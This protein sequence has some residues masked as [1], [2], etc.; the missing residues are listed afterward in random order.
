MGPMKHFWRI[1]PGTALIVFAAAL[2]LVHAQEEK[3]AAAPEAEEVKPPADSRYKGMASCASCHRQQLSQQLDEEQTRE[4]CLLNETLVFRSDET[5]SRAH[6]RLNE[7]LG[8]R[9]A[10]K[11][12]YDVSSD[13]RC[14]SCHSGWV[15]HQQKPPS[16]Q[17]GVTCEICHGPSADWREPHYD[18]AWRKKLIDEK[19]KLGMIEVREPM[20][21]A[22]LCYSCHIGNSDEGKVVSHEMYAAGHPPLP[23][24]EIETFVAAMPAHSRKLEEKGDFEFRKEF[25]AAN[26]TGASA[27]T[28]DE[29][30]RTKGVLVGGL[31]ALRESLNLF[32]KQSGPNKGT[33]FALFDCQ[34]CHHELRVPAWR[35]TRL[36]QGKPG[37]PRLPEWPTVLAEIAVAQVEPDAK[38]LQVKL[39]ELADAMGEKPFGGSR[40]VQEILSGDGKSDAGLIGWLDMR[41]QALAGRPFSKGDAKRALNALYA[42]GSNE[43]HDFHSARQIAWAIRAIETEI[44]LTYPTF[45]QRVANLPLEKQRENEENSIKIWKAWLEKDRKAA[46]DHSEKILGELSK[47]LRLTLPAGQK[48]SVSASLGSFL[49]TS[50]GYDPEKFKKLLQDSARLSGHGAAK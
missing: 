45:P 8:Q 13:Q 29:L 39:K 27:Q 33:E 41:A 3:A 9:M 37:R 16:F 50:A 24:I 2:P 4:F 35:Q 19:K 40:K 21:R 10:K 46:E 36:S 23:S 49:E 48:T 6:R 12:G 22:Q 43:V 44:Q 7:D 34:A 38:V 47:S 31:M 32:A 28:P 42:L 15:L 14:L 20:R 5:H 17:S 26:R 25:M 30:P 11:L 1:I 18:S